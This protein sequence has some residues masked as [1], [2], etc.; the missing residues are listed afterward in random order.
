MEPQR[1]LRR[2]A[3]V[4][5]LLVLFA[6]AASGQAPPEAAP[7]NSAI[8]SIASSLGVVG[9]L[10]GFRDRLDAKGI[11]FSLTYTGE[12]L[13]NVSGGLRRGAIY[14][15]L[16]DAQLDVDFDK[17]TGVP[18]L[19]F[20]AGFYQIHGRGLSRNNIGN[21][22]TMSGIEALPTARLNE[23]W[24]EQTLL[25]GKM[26]V[27]VGQL[28]AGSEFL[29][30]PTAA[31]FVNGTFG[32]PAV[33]GTNLPGGGAAYPFAT[34]GARFRVEPQQGLSLLAAIFNGDPSGGGGGEPQYTNEH[35]LRFPLRNAPMLMGEIAWAYNQDKDAT[36]LP[37]TV[38]LG[39]WYHFGT[40][41][42]QR[43]G[44]DGLSL[45][46]PASNGEARR[47]RG[48]GGIY[49]VVD[50]MLHRESGG[51]ELT[52]FS[53][54]A[55]NPSDRNQ[56]G[57]YV[58]GGLTL[59]GPIT[60]RPDD[61]AG[62]SFG[63]ARISAQARDFDRDARSFGGSGPIRSSE[64]LIELTYLARIVPGWTMQPD[65]QYVIRPGGRIA[66]PRGPAGRAVRNAVAVGLRSTVRY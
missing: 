27:R 61:I 3:S 21:L 26:A 35:S 40:F 18:G 47:H 63:Y 49:A 54:L 44:T 53:R 66:E 56:I 57:F 52:A 59:K 34:P 12:V 51:L 11:S 55:I 33:T 65:L 9:N 2:L 1:R 7:G 5:P 31:L 29:V 8:P 42:D 32:W 39:G 46:D 58:D 6:G 13:A 48:N 25:D 45:A 16:L 43:I 22:L 37:G 17:L 14:Q 24:L 64:A 30:S 23:L 28:A 4:P 20:H 15:G 62:I 50:Q 36:G 38:K 10:G 60:G 19:A 41:A